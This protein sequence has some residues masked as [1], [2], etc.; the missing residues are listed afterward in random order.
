LIFGLIKGLKNDIYRYIKLEAEYRQTKK[1]DKSEMA[2]RAFAGMGYNYGNYPGNKEISTLPFFKQF[3]V[4]GP[5]SMRAWGLRQLGLGS[6]ITYDSILTSSFRDRYG[7]MVL[8]FNAEYRFTMATI[9]GVKIGSA[10]YSDIGNIWNLKKNPLDPKASFSFSNLANDLAIGLGTGLRLDFSY[11]LIRLDFAYKVKDPMRR[12]N[13][14]WM[15]IKNFN[16]TDT[17]SNGLEVPNYAL[18]LGIGLPF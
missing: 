10:L 9:A 13:E 16:W 8:E 12:V 5:Y 1:W 17:R 7:D 15:S 18:Q 6:S 3:S 4:G 11:F 2:Y 14:G